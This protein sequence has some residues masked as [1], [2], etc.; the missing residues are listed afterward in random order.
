MTRPNIFT[1][2][3]IL[4]NA[5]EPKGRVFPVGEQD[6]G[7]AWWDRPE[8]P[9]T[10][11]EG[12]S[13]AAASLLKAYERIATLEAADERRVYDLAQM[14]KER[15]EANA[16]VAGL[17]AA[18]ADAEA[19]RKVA[20]DRAIELTKDRDRLSGFVTEL[21]AKIA[22]MDPDGDGS[23]GGSVKA[24]DDPDAEEKAALRAELEALDQPAPHHKTGLAKLRELVA[25]AKA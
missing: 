12:A 21:Q 2:D 1:V 18:K 7:P 23:P 24:S 15:D 6:P 22:K 19:D 5:A 11:E 17:E 16:K 8:G 3:T 10:A 14:A 20:E 13:E 25:E 9:P 4:Y